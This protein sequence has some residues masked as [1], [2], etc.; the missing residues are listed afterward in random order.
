MA[1]AKKKQD[2]PNTIASNRRARRDF[3]ISDTLECGI[4]LFGSEVKSLREAQVSI[5]DAYAR[6]IGNELWLIGLHIGPYS[7]SGTGTTHDAERDRKLLAHRQEIDR[8]R[9]RVDLERLTLVPLSLYLKDGLVKVEI[10]VGK[11]QRE[12]DKRQ[13]IAKRDAD[14][15][16]KKAMAAGIRKAAASRS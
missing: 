15:E 13:V 12:Y 8:L 14:L 4:V 3:D 7:H 11:G 6:V 2:K 5:S 10:G 16:A 9:M 1:K